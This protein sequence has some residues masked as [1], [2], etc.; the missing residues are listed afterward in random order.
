MKERERS[1]S[2]SFYLLVLGK[3]NIHSRYQAVEKRPQTAV[4]KQ[5]GKTYN[6]SHQAVANGVMRVLAGKYEEGRRASPRSWS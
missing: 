5:S 2:F 3:Q 1:T 6:N 4:T